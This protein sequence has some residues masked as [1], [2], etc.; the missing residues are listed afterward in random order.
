LRQA[1]GPSSFS[2]VTA[3]LPTSDRPPAVSLAAHGLVHRYDGAVALD[4]V[5]L[6]VPAGAC[7]ALVGESGSGKTTLLRCFNRMVEPAAGVVTIDGTDVRA[8]RVAT[9][10]RR[11]GYVPQ[12]GGL[13]PHWRVL[14]NVALVPRLVQS[15]DARALATEALAL[16][17]LPAERFGARYPH[18]LSGGQRQRVALAR[19][20]AARPGVI[21][22]DEPFGA[23][24]AITR[25]DLQAAFARLRRA[26]RL[27]TLLV[28]HDLVEAARLADEVAVMR[29]GRI[30]QR[31]PMAALIANPA[32]EYVAALVDRASHGLL[33]PLEPL[34]PLE[35]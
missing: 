22:L 3:S 29:A 32:T 4:G 15:P 35:T 28:T 21:L 12:H 24:D 9:L 34:E 31:G 26:L 6:D 13:L 16:V 33:E 30:E 17:G 19:A 1:R 11:I 8:G 10:R 2:R 25:G 18:E 20:L 5:S 7:V 27:T 14:R 23:L